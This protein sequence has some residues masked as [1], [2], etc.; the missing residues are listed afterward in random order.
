MNLQEN[1]SAMQLANVQTD[2]SLANHLIIKISKEFR[3]DSIQQK[4]HS[5]KMVA[6]YEQIW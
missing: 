2:Y 3:K 4:Q 1:M 6:A 5:I